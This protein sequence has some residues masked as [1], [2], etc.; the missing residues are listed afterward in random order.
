M[1]NFGLKKNW[2]LSEIALTANEVP[3]KFMF[4]KEKERK[5]FV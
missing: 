5:Q 3:A 1:L 2:R 4:S